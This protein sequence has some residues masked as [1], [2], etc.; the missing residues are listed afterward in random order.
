MV[1]PGPEGM[2]AGE[3]MEQ[4][5]KELAL[6]VR[7]HNALWREALSHSWRPPACKCSMS[8]RFSPA[9]RALADE[10]FQSTVFPVLTPLAFDPGRPFPHISN[11]SLSLAVSIE[12]KGGKAQFA[13]VKV[14]PSLPR[15]LPLDAEQPG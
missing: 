7:A 13:R 6:D 15:L 2:T 4:L 14:P 9:Q 12:G 1:A 3:I 8:R 11:L 10:Y 5:R